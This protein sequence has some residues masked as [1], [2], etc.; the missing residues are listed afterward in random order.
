MEPAKKQT[1][2]SVGRL[3]QQINNGTITL[4][5]RVPKK[6]INEDFIPEN[7]EEVIFN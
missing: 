1:T 6:K 3:F 4:G 7:E 2:V 5:K